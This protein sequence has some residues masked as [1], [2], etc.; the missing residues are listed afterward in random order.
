MCSSRKCYFW[1]NLKYRNVQLLKVDVFIDLQCEFHITDEYMAENLG[2]QFQTYTRL[3]N[4]FFQRFQRFDGKWYVDY[5]VQLIRATCGIP[6][7]I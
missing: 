1:I 5:N 3:P 2:L 4:L 7:H 6:S